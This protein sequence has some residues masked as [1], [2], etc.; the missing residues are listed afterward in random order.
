MHFKK[1]LCGGEG[2]NGGTK[3]YNSK[4]TTHPKILLQVATIIGFSL[5]LMSLDVKSL[6]SDLAC[7]Y[8]DKYETAELPESNM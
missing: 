8:S 2:M 4:A 7:E 6:R 3:I 1:V 5:L